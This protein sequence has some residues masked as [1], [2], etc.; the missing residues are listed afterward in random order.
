MAMVQQIKATD[1]IAVSYLSPRIQIEF[2]ELLGHHVRQKIVDDIREAK[3]YAMLFDS[4][5]DLSHTDQ[6][7]QIIRY[8]RIKEGIVEVMESF[9][10]FIPCDKKTAAD[11]TSVILQKLKDDGIPIEDCRGLGYDNAATMAGVQQ[12]CTTTH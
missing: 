5:P 1:R 2:I 12:W 8:V 6:M 9:I 7:T 10:D 11:I 3:Y 4:T